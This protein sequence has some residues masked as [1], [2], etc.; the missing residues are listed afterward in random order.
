MTSPENAPNREVRNEVI[1]EHAHTQT[2][3]VVLYA[4][5]LHSMACSL[6]PVAFLPAVSGQFVASVAIGGNK[7]C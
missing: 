6:W 3:T 2:H 4:D 1:Y 7:C 5:S